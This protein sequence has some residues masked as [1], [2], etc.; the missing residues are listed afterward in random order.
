MKHFLFTLLIALSGIQLQAQK[1]LF[2][3]VSYTPPKDSAGNNW[4]KEIKENIISY[5]IT[6]I[7]TNN[8]C[9]INLMKSIASKGGIEQD[10]ES[11]WKELVI[12]NYHPSEAPEIN[13]HDS[14]VWRLE[15]KSRGNTF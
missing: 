2:D 3:V 11:E 1:E 13:A 15:N 8:W 6:N 9:Q 7:K 12:N 4:K 14:G 5:T 10:F